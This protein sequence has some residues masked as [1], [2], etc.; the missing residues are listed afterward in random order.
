MVANKAEAYSRSGY[1]IFFRF[2]V[3]FYPNWGIS[4]RGRQ[5]ITNNVTRQR[6]SQHVPHTN[7]HTGDRCSVVLG[8]RVWNALPPSLTQEPSI[9][10]FK[11]GLKEILL[12]ENICS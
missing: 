12:T 9:N 2:Y 3:V 11:A 8:A 1:N 4:V 6:H 10:S 5:A 7:T